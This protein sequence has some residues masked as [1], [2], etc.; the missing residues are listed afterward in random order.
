M[1]TDP[2]APMFGPGQTRWNRAE[3]RDREASIERKKERKTG[4]REEGRER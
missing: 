1:S 3:S 2:K 4:G